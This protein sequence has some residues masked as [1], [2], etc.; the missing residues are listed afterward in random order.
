MHLEGQA[1]NLQKSAVLA[2]QRLDAQL[3]RVENLL[4][5]GFAH[6]Q[7]VAEG[8]H[9]QNIVAR[10]VAGLNAHADA[11]AVYKRNV[12]AGNIAVRVGAKV[13]QIGF[14]AADDAHAGDGIVH[15]QFNLGAG[16]DLGQRGVHFRGRVDDGSGYVGIQ[17]VQ[18]GGVE[19][20][21]VPLHDARLHRAVL[22]RD[23]QIADARQ[24]RAA[25][26]T[27]HGLAVL[28]EHFHV[29]HIVAVAVQHRVD[30][31]GVGDYV[32]VGIRLAAGFVAQMR[33]GDDIGRALGARFVN[34]LL[35]GV[36]QLLAGCAFEEA[37][38]EVA[39][40]I[41]EVLRRGGRER[42]RRGNADEGD[43]HAVEFL[44]DVGR[45]L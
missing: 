4:A 19:V 21:A 24:L 15:G 22:G 39:V 29:I 30:A 10:N 13:A 2:G 38:D 14:G 3:Q 6:A 28:I 20:R 8:M 36:I 26:L 45:K 7:H 41:L 11:A 18:L 42:L 9:L 5:G 27:Q 25:A 37:V 40:F 32:G 44:N 12:R 34:G 33:H 35:N 31:G 16:D 43:L 23:L 17:R 1:G